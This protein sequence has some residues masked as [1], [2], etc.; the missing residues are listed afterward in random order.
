MSKINILKKHVAELIA[1]GEV[2]ERP[3]SV[4]KELVENSIDAKS[5]NVTVE[6]KNGGITYMRVSDDGEGIEREDVKKAFLKNATSKI[7]KE[8]DLNK[9][10]TLGF[11]GEALP[12]ISAVSKMEIITKAANE[13]LGTRYELLGGQEGELEDIGASKGT[14]IIVRDLFYNIP[15]RLK[16]LKKDISESNAIAKLLDCLALSHPEVSFRF[17]RDGKEILDTPGD[18]KIESAIYSVYGKE[19]SEGLIPINY[20][21]N[22]LKVSGFISLPSKARPSRSMQHFFINGRYVKTRTAMVALEEAYKGSIMVQKFPSCVIYI[23]VPFDCIDVN[24]HP[25]KVE[26]RFVNEKPVFELI[27]H[28]VKS[29]LLHKD[30]PINMQLGVVKP[31]HEKNSENTVKQAPLEEETP[32]PDIKNGI[33]NAD[34]EPLKEHRKLDLFSI[35]SNPKNNVDSSC[36]DDIEIFIPKKIKNTGYEQG[37]LSYDLFNKNT[38]EAEIY[39]NG[40][41]TSAERKEL[42]SKEIIGL[43]IKEESSKNIKKSAQDKARVA[44]SLYNSF[45]AIKVPEAGEQAKIYPSEGDSIDSF[46]LIGEVFNTYIIAQINKTDLIIIDKHAAHERLIYEDLMAKKDKPYSQV[47]LEPVIVTLSKDE[48]DAVIN[49]LKLFEDAGFMVEDFGEGTVV[50]RA[51]PLALDTPDIKNIIIE[52]AAHILEH[53]SDIEASYKQWLYQNVACRAAIK[54]GL[55]CEREEIW[56]LIEKLKQNPNIKYCPHGR[57]ISMIIK[58][59]EIEKQFGRA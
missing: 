17:I 8:D 14:S 51:T 53:K 24:V 40:N 37:S 48:Y 9:I 25:S 19:F 35:N 2:V 28:G 39:K 57:P 7:F 43:N 22:N 21:L 5:K 34:E 54:G 10:S 47:L 42:G 6:I 36:E 58:K 46:A 49:N 32:E 13:D 1:A 45:D 59:S 12:S 38:V 41:E 56:T 55:K 20:S 30:M 18:D 11:R 29:A 26:V 44:E 3:S 16:F 27:Y 23:S 31:T 15:A 4:I 50:T 52:M 33:L